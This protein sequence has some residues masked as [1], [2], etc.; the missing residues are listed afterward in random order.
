MR[1][2]STN[3]FFTTEFVNGSQPGAKSLLQNILDT[4]SLRLN[5]LR[6]LHH[7]PSP[8]VFRNE[9]FRD[10][11]EKNIARYLECAKAV[12]YFTD[13]FH[14]LRLGDDVRI[15]AKVAFDQV[16]GFDNVRTR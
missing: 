1:E 9:Y 12:F 7:T 5:I 2:S 14:E 10:G 16:V 8:Q 15:P 6:R 4:K 13:E 3:K 11:D